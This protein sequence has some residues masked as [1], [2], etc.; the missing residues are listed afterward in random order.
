MLEKTKV[1]LIIVSLALGTVSCTQAEAIKSKAESPHASAQPSSATATSSNTTK[2]GYGLNPGDLNKID[3][4]LLQV[5]RA[6]QGDKDLAA[7]LLKQGKEEMEKDRKEGLHGGRSGLAKAFCGSATSYPTV[8]ALIGCAEAMS[9]E[10]TNYEAKLGN[11]KWSSELYQTALLFKDRTNAPLP[12]ADRKKVEANIACLDAFT[13]SPNPEKPGCELV[14]V[15]LLDPD[16]PGGKI[17][18]SPTGKR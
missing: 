7:K 2:P 15:S 16:L 14:R 11:F 6:N 9:L 12:A 17:L 4:L 5:N 1:L 18:P 13:R 10:Q 3:K 8:E